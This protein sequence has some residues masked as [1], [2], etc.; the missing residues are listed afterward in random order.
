MGEDSRTAAILPSIR[1]SRRRGSGEVVAFVLQGG[2][3][4]TATQVG[5]L[6]ALT[7][8][9]VR[10]DLVIGS[11][12]GALNAV[13]FASDPTGQG[14]DRLETLWRGVRRASVAPLSALTLL[15]ALRGRSEGLVSNRGLRRLMQSYLPI[16]DLEQT[17]IPA[18]VVATDMQSGGAV[19]L[20]HGDAVGA[21]LASAAFPGLYP[22]VRVGSRVLID[23]GVSADIPVPQA[24][25]LG[26][27]VTYVL[28]AALEEGAREEPRGPL[29]LAYRALGQILDAVAQR[30]IA[31]AHGQVLTLPSI[32]S[33]ATNPVDFRDTARLI[34]QGYAGA[35][36]WLAARAT[37]ADVG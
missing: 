29:P 16:A 36:H 24:E 7:E 15:Q 31:A 22:P 5:M 35:N 1:P 4:L 27:S 23:G 32:T 2:G 12:A 19:V 25:A 11:S 17:V 8:S 10:P 20:S 14:L 21:L 3:S 6:R 9:G 28:P 34:H 33:R 18:Y 30:D 37:M 26:A 13:A